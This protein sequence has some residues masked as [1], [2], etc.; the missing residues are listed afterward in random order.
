MKATCIDPY[1]RWFRAAAVSFA[2]ALSCAAPARAQQAESLYT[3]LAPSACK[4]IR[5]TSEESPSSTQE[6][7]GVAGYRLLVHDDDLR[8]SI[9]LITPDG[10]EHPLDLWQT[11]S[12]AFSSV[13][14]KAEWRVRK[15]GQKVVPYALIVRLNANESPD[16]PEKATSYLAVAKITPGGICVTDKIP[17]GAGQNERARAAADASA[18]KACVNADGSARQ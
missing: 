10:K 15:S 11:I 12:S 5:A 6:C 8:Q 9:T 2:A 17:P 7:R 4:T 14:P 3:D 1:T 13:G 16:R 18:G